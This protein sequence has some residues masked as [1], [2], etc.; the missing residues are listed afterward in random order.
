M[1]AMADFLIKMHM[2]FSYTFPS[3]QPQRERIDA[4]TY[5]KSPFHQPMRPHHCADRNCAGYAG[6]Q[7]A[8]SLRTMT[9]TTPFSISI[10]TCWEIESTGLTTCRRKSLP[11]I[12]AIRQST[13]SR[14]NHPGNSSVGTNPSCPPKNVLVHSQTPLFEP[15]P[16]RSTSPAVALNSFRLVQK[17][18]SKNTTTP[19]ERGASC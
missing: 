10:C 7:F 9:P 1:E 3:F 13:T 14:T 17:Q 4:L 5:R 11:S 19:T 16:S 2:H 18:Q 8:E 12:W 15:L 6:W